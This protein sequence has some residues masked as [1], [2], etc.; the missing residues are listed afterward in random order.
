MHYE[1]ALE[2]RAL[3]DQGSQV[4]L[5]SRQAVQRLGLRWE[6]SELAVAGVTDTEAPRAYG[7]VQLNIMLIGQ[8]QVLKVH[9]L[10][11]ETIT[12]N[13]PTSIMSASKHPALNMLSLADEHY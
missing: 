7:R 12:M 2:M 1:G 4:S 13:L 11:F 9:A 5:I 8:Q 6:K 3:I 10:V